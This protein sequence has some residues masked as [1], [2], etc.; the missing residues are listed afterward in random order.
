MVRREDLLARVR[1]NPKGVRFSDLCALANSYGWILDRQSG[2]HRIFK[3]RGHR[4]LMNFQDDGGK[5]MPY[6][7]RQLIRAI[8]ELRSEDA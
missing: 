7:V 5:A 4:Q 8:D 1:A 6:Q 3:R 2:S